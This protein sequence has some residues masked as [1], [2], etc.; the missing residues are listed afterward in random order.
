MT[1]ALLM[2]LRLISG[3]ASWFLFYAKADIQHVLERVLPHN[4]FDRKLVIAALQALGRSQR[5][6]V[7]VDIVHAGAQ[8]ALFIGS[9]HK[10]LLDLLHRILARALYI[11]IHVD[12]IKVVLLVVPQHQEQLVRHRGV[13]DRKVE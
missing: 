2:V 7:I 8:P 3:M 4:L 5:N 6:T 11:N 13:F 10:I 9:Q 1:V 12:V